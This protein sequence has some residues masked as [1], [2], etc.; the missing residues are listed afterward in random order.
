MIEIIGYPWLPSNLLMMNHHLKTKFCL[1]VTSLLVE[2]PVSLSDS[3]PA[4]IYMDL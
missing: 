2:S 3:L 4:E 1:S